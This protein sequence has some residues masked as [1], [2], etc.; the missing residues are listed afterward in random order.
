MTPDYSA[1]VRFSVV[2][3][4]GVSLAIYINGVAN[5]LYELACATPKDG[6]KGPAGGSGTRDV[7]RRLSALVGDAASIESYGAQLRGIQQPAQSP[8]TGVGPSAD[9][10]IYVSYQRTRFVV[11]VISG[12]S[13]GGINGIF[14]A[15]ALANGE[16]FS[17]LKKLWVD[18]ADIGLLL[19]DSP[20]YKQLDRPDRSVKPES[21]LNS[22]RMY[23]KLL[24]ALNAISTGNDSGES[25]VV[26]ELDL[27]V[28][29]TDIRGSTV[30][31]RLFDK[32]VY[33]R[34]H[35]QVYRFH[36][37]GTTGIVS[38]NDFVSANNE[39]LAFAARCTSSFPIAF[40]PMTLDAVTRLRADNSSGATDVRRWDRFFPDLPDEEVA[41]GAHLKR[42][43]GDG[44]YLDNKPF[45]YAI[46]A[47]SSRQGAVPLER[48]LIYVEPSPEHLGPEVVKRQHDPP[49]AIVNSFA[50]VAQIPRY[51]T[52]RED[53][54]EV[55]RRN[56]R[57]E[58]VD[59]IIGLGEVDLER[60]DPFAGVRTLSDG[61]IPN[62]STLKLSA[63]RGFYGNAFLPYRRL[64][65]FTVTD[66]L[67]DQLAHCWNVERKSDL[68]YALRALVRAW[69]DLHFDEEASPGDSRETINSF[70]NRFDLSYR[71]RR[72]GFLLRK[73]DQLTRLFSKNLQGLD[74]DDLSDS[75]RLMAERLTRERSDLVDL[76]A[77]TIDDAAR[78]HT[79]AALN[80]LK[81]GMQ[82]VQA[83]LRRTSRQALL[84]VAHAPVL[85][86]VLQSE[87][88]EALELLL[89][90]R[91]TEAPPLMLSTQLGTPQPVHLPD[92]LLKTASATR[93]LQE[94]IYARAKWL[95]RAAADKPSTRLQLELER[96]LAA[97]GDGLHTIIKGP[98][99]NA[100]ESASSP[101]YSAAHAWRLLGSP[102][103]AV[104]QSEP[105]KVAIEVTDTGE[106]VLDT[107][108]GRILRRVIG[109]YYL[110]FD[111]FDQMSFPLYYDTG[112]GEPV[113][114]EVVRISPEDAPSL[115]NELSPIERRRKLAGTA[116]AHFGAFLDE[117]FRRNDIMWGRLDGAERLISALL[118]SPDANTVAARKA[119]ITEAHGVI[120]REE[121]TPAGYAQLSSLFCEALANTTGLTQDEKL[122]RLIKALGPDDPVKG[123][124]L[125]EILTSLMS[126]G[127][128][129]A[130]VRDTRDIDRTPDP[131]ASMSNAARSVTIA[132][133]LLETIVERDGRKSA[134]LRWVARAGQAA[135]GL[136]AVSLPGSF[137]SLWWRHGLKV[138]YAFELFVLA[139][140][141]L[142]GAPE[143]RGVALTALGVTA[144]LHLISLLAADKM[145]RRNGW[146][147]AMTWL[148][149]LV[150]LALAALGARTFAH[151]LGSLP[152]WP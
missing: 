76:N 43:F 93:T 104:T 137:G 67:A 130:Y 75:D 29:T 36:Y 145:R 23:L 110:R 92:R 125:R 102:K 63:L 138:L 84:D 86:P 96:S 21:L 72:L 120:L 44:G 14:L 46:Q 135:Q 103:L 34:R 126:E 42:A 101:D 106:D 98:A 8:T 117:R 123:G 73:I 40:E 31:L 109:E 66:E 132:G 131:A 87:L 74:P 78:S 149:A 85:D 134:G 139:I 27:F 112:T 17:P 1:E 97:L 121:L 57:I 152:R 81:T 115:I 2:M 79:L 48:K 77:A 58:R 11:D 140:S 122:Q 95:F 32:V 62:W 88:L 108:E 99:D 144:V 18:E 107:I 33:E 82:P 129:L 116:L 147:R 100:P 53:L 128:L 12:T 70:L 25:P 3:Y 89:G 65:V 35:K 47:L 68:V 80:R 151:W 114:V 90:R 142:A 39:F 19:N 20:S 38:A 55:L 30:P 37:E 49:N 13:A 105:H 26:D 6:G 94:T 111:S 22:D 136:V 10:G 9:P 143:T 133:R 15:K 71:I 51:E 56:R 28:T 4:G 60:Q 119:L 141:L 50:A 24:A 16:P 54:Q 64:R 7:Y 69:R 83:N 45:G 150:L 148:S 113:T 124:R 127:G 5:E 61:S 118:P 52:I 146:L 59:R 91:P 41:A